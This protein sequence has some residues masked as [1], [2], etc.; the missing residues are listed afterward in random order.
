VRHGL[1]RSGGRQE[2]KRQGDAELEVKGGGGG[3]GGGNVV[4]WG[5]LSLRETARCP[6]SF[7]H[8]ESWRTCSSKDELAKGDSAKCFEL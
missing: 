6:A 8:L 3:R 7:A 1:C 4:E 5:L 2:S